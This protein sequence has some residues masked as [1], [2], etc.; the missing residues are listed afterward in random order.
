MVFPG[1]FNDEDVRAAGR[2][3]LLIAD[4]QPDVLEALRML[5]KPAGYDVEMAATPREVLERLQGGAFDAVIMDLNYTLDTTSGSEGMDLLSAVKSR[6]EAL[7]VI[8]M[9]AWV[10]VELAIEALRRGASDF[11]QKPWNNAQVLSTVTAQVARRR[12]VTR[13][14]RDRQSELEDARA[15]QRALLPHDLPQVAGFELLAWTR[16]ARHVGGDYYDV[17]PLGGQRVAFIIADV[18]GKGIPAALTMSNLQGALKTL[19]WDATSPAQLC[20]TLN[21]LLRGSMVE[22]RFVSLFCGI[23]DTAAG[24]IDFCNA[25]HQPPLAVIRGGVLRLESGGAVL[26]H[27]EDWPYEDGRLALQ[28]G[29]SVLLFTDGIPDARNAA[30]EEFLESGMTAAI[31]SNAPAAGALRDAVLAAVRR[32]CADQFED[33]ATLL[34]LRRND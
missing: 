22:G 34:V 21:Q 31:P 25:G 7:P 5:L 15:V 3:R 27:F 1:S 9:T 26:G 18:C 32:H 20:R 30:G 33:D 4:D 16:P 23:L 6:D 2:A 29:E 24:T 19:I 17:I 11:I 8:V 10:T 28:P 14:T 13:V 12:L